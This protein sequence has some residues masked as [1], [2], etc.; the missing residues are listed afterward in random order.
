VEVK[1]R[2]K[3]TKFLAGISVAILA[4]TVLNLPKKH[5]A[6]AG[7]SVSCSSSTIYVGD[8]VT[9]TVSVSGGAGMVAVSG[10]ANDSDWFE[11]N[12]RSYT[13]KGTSAGSLSVYASGTIADFNTEKDQSLSSSCT[14]V[15]KERSKPSNNN[16][17]SSSNSGNNDTPQNNNDDYNNAPSNN[18]TPK[19]EP[20]NKTE[21]PKEEKKNKD[22]SL[23]S[24][25]ISEGKLS[26]AFQAGTTS[27][28]VDLPG[29]VDTLKVSAA[30]NNSKASLRGIGKKKLKPG[31]NTIQVI[32]TAENGTSTT[33]T[34]K[35]HVDEKPLVFVNYQGKKLGVSRSAAKLSKKLFEETKLTID[36]KV[37]PAWTN[38][39]L[40]MTLLYLEN[41]DKKDFYFYDTE[42]KEVTSIY[43]PVGLLGENIAIIDVPKALQKRTG[44][45]FTTVKV[46]GKELP[47]WTYQDKAFADYALLYVMNDAGD[48]VYYQYE[49]TGNTLQRYAGGAAIT[50]NA[51]E[52]L[53]KAHEEETKQLK[54][55]V[56][57]L[58]ALSAI[59]FLAILIICVKKR[60]PKHF[61]KIDVKGRPLSKSAEIE[62]ESL[63]KMQ[64]EDGE[65]F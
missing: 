12:S 9:F 31:N 28:K 10:A 41:D 20:S 21:K 36:G 65:N 47:G 40:H 19:N 5:I 32:C 8:T 2:K 17:N 13:V 4:V 63:V 59:L 35:V 45:V 22:S 6:A 30:A 16:N 56:Y 57:G 58:C 48:K 61:N 53:L 7:L 39:S 25:S 14:V 15:V 60:K 27:Y 42:K 55:I 43:R 51:Y 37:V 26:P 23:K 18:D 33:Y 52:K 38:K 44:M 49:K 54:L 34:I 11:N 46:D 64:Q 1:M 24:L 3:I 29:S 62:H 50:Q